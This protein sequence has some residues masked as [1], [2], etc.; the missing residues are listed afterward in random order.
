MLVDAG[1]RLNVRR[2]TRGGWRKL[3]T[4][5]VDFT[6]NGELD[7]AAEELLAVALDIESEGRSKL[8]PAAA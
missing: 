4:R 1:V 2:G 7:P 6:M 5:R 3:D 8:L